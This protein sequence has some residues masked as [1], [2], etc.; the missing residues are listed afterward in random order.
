MQ[1]E[2]PSAPKRSEHRGPPTAVVIAP[3]LRARLLLRGLLL[4]HHVQI[5]GEA[6]AFR[7]GL[8]MVRRTRPSHLLIDAETDDPAL[9]DTIAQAR[10]FSPVTKIVLIRP[11]VRGYASPADP[12]KRPDVLLR[13]PFTMLEF[14]Q[15]LYSAG[16]EPVA[17]QPSDREPGA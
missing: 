4:M 2:A 13:E 1:S 15:A 14:A 12:S 17:G 11:A 5:D 7:T 3:E 6:D 10:A 8:E 9:A 16:F